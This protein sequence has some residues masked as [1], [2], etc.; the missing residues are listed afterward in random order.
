MS[1]CSTG[2]SGDHQ[3]RGVCQRPD[4]CSPFA[5]ERVC[6]SWKDPPAIIG[7]QTRGYRARYRPDNGLHGTRH[8]C[9]GMDEIR[10]GDRSK[11]KAEAQRYQGAFEEA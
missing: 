11:T 5:E 9:K 10:Q 1:R 4:R 7:I 2:R 6:L 3:L 8:L